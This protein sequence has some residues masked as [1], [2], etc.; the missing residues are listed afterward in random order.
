MYRFPLDD[1][2][3]SSVHSQKMS[4]MH[5]TMPWILCL[6][7]PSL[8][9]DAFMAAAKKWKDKNDVRG[10]CLDAQPFSIQ[11][12]SVVISMAPKPGAGEDPQPDKK[13]DIMSANSFMK[14][15]ATRSC[16]QLKSI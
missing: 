15:N 8:C 10:I 6:L 3:K 5:Q 12:L 1:G 16:I 2:C 14:V 11:V 9:H 13:R 4:V 7:I